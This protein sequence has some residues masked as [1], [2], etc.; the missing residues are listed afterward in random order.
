VVLPRAGLRPVQ[1]AVLLL[2]SELAR[3][4]EGTGVTANA[5]DPGFVATGIISQ[6][7]GRQWRPIQR[8][9]NCVAR[10]PEEGAQVILY[11]ATSP[12]V[13]GVSG[14]CF[15]IANTARASMVCHDE[16]A[17]RQLWQICER[18]TA[19]TFPASDVC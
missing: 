5:V 17:A 7:A 15:K 14:R 19:E 8:V 10:T 2:T 9:L 4:L 3:R 18:M 1:A 16:T 6:N 12:D 11:L 13:L